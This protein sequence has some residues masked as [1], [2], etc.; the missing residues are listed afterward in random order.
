M[1]TAATTSPSRPIILCVEDAADLPR[2][3][4]EELEEAGYQVL[5]AGTGEV[6][7]QCLADCP[8]DLVLC[9]ISKPLA[10][11]YAVLRALL[12]QQ[13]DRPGIPFIVLSALCV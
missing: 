5:E 13:S 1:S 9:D 4:V 8:P 6:A 3:L 10:S 2:D 12:D 7:L 11:G